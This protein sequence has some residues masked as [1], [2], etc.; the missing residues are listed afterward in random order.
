MR[1]VCIEP[2]PLVPQKEVGVHCSVSMATTAGRCFTKGEGD[3]GGGHGNA[4]EEEEGPLERRWACFWV[5]GDYLSSTEMK[6]E[7]V[8][9]CKGSD[10]NRE[11]ESMK[12]KDKRREIK[13]THVGMAEACR[14]EVK[15]AHAEAS[16]RGKDHHTAEKN[17]RALGTVVLVSNSSSG[18]C[19]RGTA[20]AWDVW[21]QS[22]VPLKRQQQLHHS[23]TSLSLSFL[24]NRTCNSACHDRWVFK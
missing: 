19:L 2:P 20:L 13:E 3:D 24:Y 22:P 16:R 18:V 17:A 7:K 5:S 1:V 9:N 23:L 11:F 6:D 12:V 14:R 8:M 21:V 10:D 4:E 15:G